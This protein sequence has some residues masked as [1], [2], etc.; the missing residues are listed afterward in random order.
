MGDEHRHVVTLTAGQEVEITGTSLAN[1]HGFNARLY[2]SV[3]GKP[4]GPAL[5]EVRPW[6]FNGNPTYLT[7][8][9]SAYTVTQ[10]GEYVVAI[11]RFELSTADI[12]DATDYS[13]TLRVAP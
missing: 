8:T 11:D 2:Q 6:D 5:T 9:S 13:W 1:Q 12:R 10:T 4:Q 7:Q 3:D